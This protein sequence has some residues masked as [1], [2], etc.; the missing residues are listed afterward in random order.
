MQRDDPGNQ[1]EPRHHQY[2][3]PDMWWNARMSE[4]ENRDGPNQERSNYDASAID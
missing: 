3:S 1:N 2:G 4:K